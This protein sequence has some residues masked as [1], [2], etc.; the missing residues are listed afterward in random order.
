[1]PPV[2]P[3]GRAGESPRGKAHDGKG[4]LDCGEEM[5]PEDPLQREVVFI[6]EASS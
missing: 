1:M 4:Q 5:T 3:G 2:R 6:P